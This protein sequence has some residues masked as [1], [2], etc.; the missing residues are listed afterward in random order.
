MKN[1]L[2]R[3]KKSDRIK[4]GLTAAAFVL[5]A[6]L[7]VGLCLQV[8]GHGKAQPS[9]W[10][11]KQDN[12]EQTTPETDDAKIESPITSR[13]RMAANTTASAEYPVTFEGVSYVVTDMT[14]MENGRDDL[15]SRLTFGLYDGVYGFELK[16]EPNATG[17]PNNQPFLDVVQE[18]YDYGISTGRLECVQ[19]GLSFWYSE[20]GQAGFC[21]L[22]P[23]YIT[24]QYVVEKCLSD[25][26]YS[27]GDP[28]EVYVCGSEPNNG[29][30]S[31]QIKTTSY[32]F[33]IRQAIESDDPA[34]YSWLCY[35]MQT[36]GDYPESVPSDGGWDGVIGTSLEMNGVFHYG[37][38]YDET[39]NYVLVIKTNGVSCVTDELWHSNY[40]DQTIN[41]AN[42][43]S[44]SKT[45]RET[46]T[47]QIYW[48]SDA[49]GTPASNIIT[50]RMRSTKRVELPATP[51]K[52]GYKFTGWYMDEACT[53]P[54][55]GRPVFEETQFYAGWQILA[56]FVSFVPNNG[57]TVKDQAVNWGSTPTLPNVTR[58]GYR[59]LGWY[60]GDT[61][62]DNMP[63]KSEMTL[64]AKWEIYT[65]KVTFI[66]GDEVISEMTVEWGTGF[67]AVK[68]KA[69]A[70][71]KDIVSI[72]YTSG[73][74]ID[75]EKAI[76]DDNV[77]VQVADKTTADKV[78]NG[79]KQ[80]W[81][82]IAIAAGGVVALVLVISLLAGLKKKPRKARR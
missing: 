12:T 11:K 49:Q 37:H 67:G 53:I 68:E 59:F 41:I 7:L 77:T 73:K 80:N 14:D 61:L 65:F 40:G 8:F 24:L 66:S 57:T 82:T 43:M 81:K 4:W 6:V 20:C 69:A 42:Y 47:S 50:F 52:E 63:V 38:S 18:W 29:A 30:P 2:R 31:R 28:V 44:S 74:P 1:E 17:G 27:L 25:N 58:E 78:K 5:V 34:D 16:A 22:T 33:Y 48:A 75:I 35:D 32:S 79:I 71:D 10:F 19:N 72:A 55:D 70:M 76:V 26:T 54:Y 64:T 15:P 56:Y 39:K 45:D 60:N 9:E 13:V 3:H 23:Q 21:S 62:Y 36:S 46:Y 51:T